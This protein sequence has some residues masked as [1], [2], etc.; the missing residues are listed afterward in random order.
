MRYTGA[1]GPSAAMSTAAGGIVKNGLRA[2]SRSSYIT[3]RMWA[4]LLQTNLRP[5]LSK[6]S[7]YWPPPLSKRIVSVRGSK[8]K[9]WPRKSRGYEVPPSP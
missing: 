6:L 1:A 7:P 3:S 2:E 5:R 9:S 8:D 4:L